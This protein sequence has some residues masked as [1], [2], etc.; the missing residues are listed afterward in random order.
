MLGLRFDPSLPLVA[1]SSFDAG[2]DKVAAGDA[3]DW[4]ARG[5]SE[6]DAL[7]LFSS[8]IVTFAPAAATAVVQPSPAKPPQQPRRGR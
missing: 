6:L 1:T 5:L 7:T 3:F 2:G 8:G 4:R